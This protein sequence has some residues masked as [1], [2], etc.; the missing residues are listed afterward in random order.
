MDK[1]IKDEKIEKINFLKIDIE[2]YEKVAIKGMK[3]SLKITDYLMIEI[4]E[5]SVLK[6]LKNFKLIDKRG[7]NYFFKNLRMNNFS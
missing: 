5:K 4:K 1:I 3:K 7:E 2:G 6:K